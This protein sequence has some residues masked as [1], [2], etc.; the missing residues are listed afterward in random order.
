M[1]VYIFKEVEQLTSNYHCDGGLVVVA[2]DDEQ[3]AKLIIGA[4]KS[5][6]KETDDFT[7]AYADI[8]LTEEEWGNVIIYPTD[9]TV[10]PAIYVFPDAGCC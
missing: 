8:E 5:T 6:Y 7:L 10:E 4:N 2:K 1:N 9:E 3:V